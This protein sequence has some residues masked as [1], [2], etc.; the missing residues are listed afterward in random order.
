MFF[1]AS[2]KAPSFFPLRGLFYSGE[3]EQI[4][5]LMKLFRNLAALGLFFSNLH[6]VNHILFVTEGDAP[7]LNLKHCLSKIDQCKFPEDPAK[8]QLIKEYL[9]ANIRLFQ[10]EFQ[11]SMH[12]FDILA[13]SEA[14]AS[15]INKYS[16]VSPY[17]TPVEQLF[18]QDHTLSYQLNNVLADLAVNKPLGY[19]KIIAAIHL[20]NRIKALQSDLKRDD[21]LTIVTLGVSASDV[22]NLASWLVQ[23]HTK[24]ALKI[25][26]LVAEGI[27]GSIGLATGS[28]PIMILAKFGISAI[29][30][31]GKDFIAELEKGNNELAN[32]MLQV[33]EQKLKEVNN[34][35]LDYLDHK[36]FEFGD[37]ISVGASFHLAATWPN[38][39][40]IDRYFNFYS[41]KD[42][43]V[44]NENI[45]LP[46]SDKR[47]RNAD[48]KNVFNIST[49]FL[50]P[51]GG[52][53]GYKAKKYSPSHSDLT[54]NGL[55]L[56]GLVCCACDLDK[57]S[58]TDIEAKFDVQAGRLVSSK[59]INKQKSKMNK[60]VSV[61]STYYHQYQSKRANKKR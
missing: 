1:L 61:F 38:L 56:R 49:K 16:P 42:A 32:K 30:G 48:C 44:F 33:H 13:Y 3:K 10:Q 2:K 45:L 58:L 17:N 4:S 36:V 41:E 9:W 31:A 47:V 22:F 12:V 19:E 15:R 25:G 7:R 27:L 21:K 11:V 18:Y 43:D 50:A 40:R 35:V 46:N 57:L 28:L 24:D 23:A 39:S 60:L 20:V 37:V 59:E 34:L 29:Y 14:E 26:L 8:N 54:T 6:F 53:F 51:Q 55:F 52:C 5:F